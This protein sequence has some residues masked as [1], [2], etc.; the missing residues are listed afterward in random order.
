MTKEEMINKVV[1]VFA[2]KHL[3]IEDINISYNDVSKLMDEWAKIR[4][5]EFVVWV[6]KNRFVFIGG[7]WCDESEYEWMGEPERLITTE[8]LYDLFIKQQ[9]Q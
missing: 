8:Q 4:S 9:T 7:L 1:G 2:L 3:D 5:I 6:D